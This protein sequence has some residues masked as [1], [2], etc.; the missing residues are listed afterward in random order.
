[1]YNQ[2]FKIRKLMY[3]WMII[4]IGEDHLIEAS[5]F[6]GY[7]L[8][9]KFLEKM[10]RLIRH[11]SS[12][13]LLH[14]QNEPGACIMCIENTDETIC[15]SL[16]ESK[17]DSDE[18]DPY[19]ERKEWQSCGNKIFSYDVKIND[20]LDGIVAEFSLYENG[21]GRKMYEK[22]WGDFPQEEYD[23]L[24]KIASEINKNCGRY[25]KLFCMTYL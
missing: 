2:W 5:D 7:D 24:K 16:Y 8:P 1:M 12:E 25:D 14:W 21:N 23:E 18:L 9:K 17:K 4:G 22:H 15:F 13:G 6:L 3:G 10:I 19:D 11:E 20:A